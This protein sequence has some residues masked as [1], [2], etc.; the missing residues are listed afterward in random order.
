MPQVVNPIRKMKVKQALMQ[1]KSKKEALEIAGLKPGA[2]RGNVSRNTTLNY[3]EREILQEMKE[4]DITVE[5]IINRL[6]EDREL[7]RKKNDISTMTRCDELLG[8]TIAS[9]TQKALSQVELVI[10]PE[11]KEELNRLR[12][13][14]LS[15]INSN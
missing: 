3:A 5:L 11:E 6:N 12:G 13:T 2:I 9:F 4:A 15:L 8:Q 14:V 10:K 7:A 1:G